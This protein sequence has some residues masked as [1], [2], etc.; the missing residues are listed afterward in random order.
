MLDNVHS[1]ET[2]GLL[3]GLIYTYD[4]TWSVGTVH[5]R[6]M[7]GATAPEPVLVTPVQQ[8]NVSVSTRNEE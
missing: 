2:Y 5:G 3:Y 6:S 4:Q 7:I 8:Q 1:L